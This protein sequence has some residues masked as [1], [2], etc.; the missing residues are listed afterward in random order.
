M[1]NLD[2]NKEQI[3]T[4]M[5]RIDQELQEQKNLD[6]RDLKRERELIYAKFI[7]GLKLNRVYNRYYNI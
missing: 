3:L 5:E 1:R 4:K 7:E 6:E 2:F